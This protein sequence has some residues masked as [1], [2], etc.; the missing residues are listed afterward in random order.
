[1]E[2]KV[3][4]IVEWM[5][6]WEKEHGYSQTN[7]ELAAFMNELQVQTLKIFSFKLEGGRTIIPYCG[8][9]DGIPMWQIAGGIGKVNDTYGYISDTEVGKLWE[10][11]IFTNKLMNLLGEKYN[12]LMSGWDAEG[13]RSATPIPGYDILSWDDFTSK[14]VMLNNGKGDIISLTLSDISDFKTKV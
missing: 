2:K 8:T 10:D 7:A 11:K 3:T 13:N 9:V 6:E 4:Q 5:E 12:V 14:Y 1:M